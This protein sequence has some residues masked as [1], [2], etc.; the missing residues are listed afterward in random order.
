MG[1]QV[2]AGSQ[3]S[4]A[5]GGTLPAGAG[6]CHLLQ[7]LCSQDTGEG[8][9]IASCVSGSALERLSISAL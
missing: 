7:E 1:A 2:Q 8:L 6:L 3:A 4:P 5:G 9:L